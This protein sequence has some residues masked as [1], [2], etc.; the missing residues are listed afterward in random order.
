MTPWYQAQVAI[1]G[2][3]IAAVGALILIVVGAAVVQTARLEGFKVWP[4]E[5]AGWIATATTR[6]AERDAERT[7]H[8]KTKTDYREAQADAARQ[9]ADRLDRV[10]QQQEEITNAMES[11]YRRQLADLGARAERLRKQVRTRTGAGGAPT[12]Q[13]SPPLRDP[14]SGADAAPS[15]RRLPPAGREPAGHFGRTAEEQLERDI[16]ATGQAL[17]LD[18]LI[19]WV[20]AQAAID[21]NTQP[22]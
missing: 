15:D 7:A 4:F 19:D 20:I 9:E 2:A 14:A 3:W 12:G 11:D 18:A 5:M 6:E 8:R 17:Q 16:V 1:R 21:P 13:P 22:D 10:R